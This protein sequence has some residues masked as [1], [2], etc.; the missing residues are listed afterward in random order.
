MSEA[1][2]NGSSELPGWVKSMKLKG[3]LRLRYQKDQNDGAVDRDRGRI[4]YRLGVESKV[5]DMVKVG[6]GL[7]SGSDDPRSTNETLDNTFETPDIRLDYAYAEISPLS[8][9]KL[10]GGKFPRKDYLWATTDLLWDGDINPEGVSLHVDAIDTDGVDMFVNG[11]WWTL[12]EFSSDDSDPFM[13]YVQPG[14]KATMENVSATIAGT[15]YG[16]EN[17]D[18]ATGRLDHAA[19]TNTLSGTDYMYAY[20]SYGVSGELALKLG[21][22]V[23][24][25]KVAAFADYIH[26]PDPDDNN[27]G[28]AVGAKAGSAKI[29]NPGTW[30]LKYIY[31]ELERDA[32]L[33]A[34]PDS[35]RFG[36]RTD[37]KGHEV[38][39]E[40]AVLKN[41][42][43]GL[44]YYDTERISNSLDTNKIVQAD[45]LFKF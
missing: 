14:V 4:R 23:P 16:F 29:G 20:D 13:F 6:A 22:D 43:V 40:V 28:Y 26:N 5:N 35:D 32:F 30:G 8:Q 17:L 36:G 2:A 12:D 7:A 38:A 1:K 19:G 33:D 11:G 3:D 24:V 21:T 31:A 15:Y 27:T 45:V 39:L 42:V 18:S 41:V 44:D 9:M 37:I 25:E 10:V 34:F